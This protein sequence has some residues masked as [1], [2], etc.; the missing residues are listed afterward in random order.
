PLPVSKDPSWQRE[1][2]LTREVVDQS[3]QATLAAREGR[4]HIVV[5]AP[6][7]RPTTRLDVSVSENVVSHLQ[8]QLERSNEMRGT[9]RDAVTGAAIGGATILGGDLSMKTDD[10]G[11]FE[12][13]SLPNCRFH[14]T[15]F[16]DGYR[17]LEIGG[18]RGDSNSDQRV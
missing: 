11:A 17:S 1:N 3:G 13:K 5:V 16:A 4:Q 7:F 10:S 14:L 15:I 2:L 9:V 12:S 6:G 8:V 18:I